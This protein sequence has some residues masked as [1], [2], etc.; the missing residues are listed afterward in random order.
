MRIIPFALFLFACT[1]TQTIGTDDSGKGSGD[2]S[3]TG[4]V[5]TSDTGSDSGSDSGDT[6]SRPSEFAGDYTGIVS[7]EAS[8]PDGGPNMVLCTGIQGMTVSE[9][10]EVSGTGDCEGESPDPEGPPPP[11]FAIDLAGSVTE[12]GDLSVDVTLT[13]GPGDSETA[14]EAATGTISRGTAE[15]G[16]EGTVTGPMGDVDYAA[17]MQME[18]Q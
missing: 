14:T 4:S 12:A 2:T 10:G 17:A 15:L 18:K 6:G 13:Y 1:A 8:G 3:D 16:W 11:K 5:D 7:M 9:A